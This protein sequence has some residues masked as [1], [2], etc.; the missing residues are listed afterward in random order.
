MVHN[1][2]WGGGIILVILGGDVAMGI[3]KLLEMMLLWGLK[4]LSWSKKIN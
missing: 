3:E 1:F 2:S 4:E